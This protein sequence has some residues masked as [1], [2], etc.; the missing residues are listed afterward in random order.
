MRLLWTMNISILPASGV[1]HHHLGTRLAA[2]SKALATGFSLIELMVV[3]AIVAVLAAIAA[4]S[5]RELIQNNRLA[6]A[7]SAL[8][9]SLSLARAEAVKRGS[10]AIVSIAAN[11]TAGDWVQGWTV[12][13]DKTNNAHSGVAPT[14]DDTSANRLWTR[15]E[16]TSAPS[17]PVS[18]GSTGS[19]PT[20]FSFNGQGRMV[21]PLT[22]P[23][24]IWFFNETSQKYCLMINNTG[25]VRAERVSNSTSCPDN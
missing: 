25:R 5:F 6:S 8:Q 9:V 18:F 13:V 11:G 20:Y 23:T 21:N 16:V 22:S 1:A 7:S 19:A 17:A 15:L 4:P 3:M 24:I 14:S 10:D 2:S 12:F